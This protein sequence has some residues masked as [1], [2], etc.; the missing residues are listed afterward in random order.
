M[1]KWAMAHVPWYLKHNPSLSKHSQL[2]AIIELNGG[3]DLLKGPQT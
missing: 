2:I 1:S 3:T